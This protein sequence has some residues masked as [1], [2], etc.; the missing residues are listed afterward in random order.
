MK[1]FKGY[2]LGI[3]SKNNIGAFFD[4]K[5][6]IYNLDTDTILFDDPNLFKRGE[7][8]CDVN[9][10]PNNKY[11][12]V[13]T[14]K[15][16]VAVFKIYDDHV[17]LIFKDDSLKNCYS[18]ESRF[19]VFNDLFIIGV[20]LLKENKKQ[21]YFVYSMDGKYKEIIENPKTIA[22][23]SSLSTSMQQDNLFTFY[24]QSVGEK[25][26]TFNSFRS[27]GTLINNKI[28]LKNINFC[29][30][31]ED[32]GFLDKRIYSF[33]EYR[34]FVINLHTNENYKEGIYYIDLENEKI[35]FLCDYPKIKDLNVL[36]KDNYNILEDIEYL[37][38]PKKKKIE[39]IEISNQYIYDKT[40]NYLFIFVENFLSYMYSF[41]GVRKE[42]P[43]HIKC[44][45]CDL[46]NHKLSLE[47]TYT[48]MFTNPT[49]YLDLGTVN[50]DYML[51]NYMKRLVVYKIDKD[52]NLV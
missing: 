27:N 19:L 14:F 52:G 7:E 40:N 32:N 9:F 45:K 44:Y 12:V 34:F 29:K 15:S 41:T 47:K 39:E 43:N 18:S 24:Y 5:L 42:V 6:M 2:S 25:D 16:H 20:T 10:T 37:K 49:N 35:E 1:E 3:I 30:L 51:F 50:K 17:D 28:V 48:V 26:F 21:T 13:Y 38:N 46:T 11:L 33:D 31:L 8:I 23:E 4:K 22:N 36:K